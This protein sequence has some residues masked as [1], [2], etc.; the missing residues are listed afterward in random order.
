VI[1]TEE[2]G[3]DVNLATYLLLDAFKKHCQAAVVISND[4]DLKE[5]ITVAQRELGLTVGIINPHPP[6]REAERCSQRSSSRSKS[7]PCGH[8]SFPE[9][10]PMPGSCDHAHRGQAAEPVLGDPS[11]DR[12]QPWNKEAISSA[13]TR[14]S[15]PCETNRHTSRPTTRS[16]RSARN[17]T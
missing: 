16:R 15:M 9:C 11:G 3:S 8:A 14:T 5:P 2:N 12:R 4:S 7:R 10:S 13:G 6:Q 17:P 1:K